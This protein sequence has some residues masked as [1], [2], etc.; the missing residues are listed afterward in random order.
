MALISDMIARV[1]VQDAPRAC[2]NIQS[3]VKKTHVND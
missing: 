2:A 3:A 1:G